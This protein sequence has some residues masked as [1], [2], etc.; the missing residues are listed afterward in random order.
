MYLQML[1]A[2]PTVTVAK[3]VVGFVAAG[4]ASIIAKD[5]I[6]NNIEEPDGL[7]KTIKVTG[8]TAVIALMV[9]RA[10][11][12]FVNDEIDDIAA[13]VAKFK[14]ELDKHKVTEASTE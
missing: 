10:A 12:D 13:N 6:A 14:E 9:R 5:I 11:K 1:R 4:G 2:I 3:S 8:G 7:I